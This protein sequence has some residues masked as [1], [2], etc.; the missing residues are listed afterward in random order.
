MFNALNNPTNPAH[1]YDIDLKKM[2]PVKI[3]K[4]KVS[5]DSDKLN[6]LNIEI[7]NSKLDD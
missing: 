3:H 2:E 1:Y 7:S 5:D 6:C 4:G